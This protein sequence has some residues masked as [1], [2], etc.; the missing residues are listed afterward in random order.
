MRLGS[1]KALNCFEACRTCPLEKVGYSD[2]GSS[3]KHDVGV[4]IGAMKK[5]NPGVIVQ[6]FDP[7]ER[8][9]ELVEADDLEVAK[10][11]KASWHCVRIKQRHECENPSVVELQPDDDY[12]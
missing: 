5:F 11:V 4:I 7:P 8:A 12:L 6:N 10:F 3:V 1:V 9:L 2:A